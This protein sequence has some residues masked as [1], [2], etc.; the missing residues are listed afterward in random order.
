MATE[1]LQLSPYDLFNTAIISK[2]DPTVNDRPTSGLGTLWVNKTAG[3]GFIL[4]SVAANTATWI[5]LGGGGVAGALLTI[6]PGDI[7]VTQGNVIVTA[8]HITSG[9]YIA[10]GSYI[11]AITTITAGTGITATTGNI[12]ATAGNISTTAG[13]IS[14]HTTLTAGTGITSTTGNIVATA[15]SVTAGTTVVATTTVTGGTGVI[16]TTGNITATAGGFVASTAGQGVTLGG[17]AKIVC[18][19][20]DP[21][22]FVTAPQGSLYLNLTGSTTA[23]RLWVNSTG[24]AVWVA[25][26]TAS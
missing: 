20:G 12:V 5:G 25:V 2:R 11:T 4:T 21:N 7:T 16:A 13:S 22:T 6:N 23:N 18:G 9:A 10:S 8:G 24:A 15:G 3:T 14:A 1:I 17:G 26:T 19:T